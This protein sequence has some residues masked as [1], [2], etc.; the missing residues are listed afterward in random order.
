MSYEEEDTCHMM[1]GVHFICGGGYMS[2]DE[3]GTQFS[4]NKE[5]SFLVCV[6]VCVVRETKI[7]RRALSTDF[8]EHGQ[9]SDILCPRRLFHLCSKVVNIVV[10]V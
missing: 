8:L 7:T 4:P 2:Y 9:Q 6:C 5:A 3:G 1:R 10:N